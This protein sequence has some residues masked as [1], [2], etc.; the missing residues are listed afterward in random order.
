MVELGSGTRERS[1]NSDLPLG[2]CFVC[3]R[4]L[5]KVG[6]RLR[7]TLT[8]EG[9][10]VEMIAVARVVKSQLRMDLDPKSHAILLAWIR[11]LPKFAN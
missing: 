11:I 2:G 5:L 4:P 9:R 1:V 7:R 10:E 3:T 8:H 6:A